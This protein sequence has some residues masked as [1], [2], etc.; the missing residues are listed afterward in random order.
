MLC[1]GKLFTNL[2]LHKNLKRKKM[3]L[4]CFGV[5]LRGFALGGRGGGRVRGRDGSGGVLSP[6]IDSE[7]ASELCCALPAWV[8]NHQTYLDP[9][10]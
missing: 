5:E 4:K 6:V 3:Q 10:C 2:Y 8:Q 1:C 9:D 7:H